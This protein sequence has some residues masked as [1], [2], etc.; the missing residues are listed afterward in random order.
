MSA[1]PPGVPPLADVAHDLMAVKMYSLATFVMVYYDIIITFGDEVERVWRR[2]FTWF[3]VLWFLNQYVPPLG[4]VVIILAFH[5]SAW[6]ANARICDAV[7][8]FPA[9]LGAVTGT[10]IDVIFI[11]RLYATFSAHKAVLVFM[12]PL[13]T[14]KEALAI[15]SVTSGQRL[16]LPPGLVGCILIAGPQGNLR[17]TGVWIAQLCFDA[18]VFALTVYRALALSRVARGGVRSLIDIIVRDGVVY[19]AVIFVADLVN[20]LTFL[21]APVRPFLSRIDMP[22]AD[23]CTRAQPALQAANASFTIAIAPLMVSRLIL[24][25]RGAD[26]AQKTRVRASG[27]S[28]ARTYG[29]GSNAS[30]PRGVLGYVHPMYETPA[31]S[32]NA[33]WKSHGSKRRWKLSAPYTHPLWGPA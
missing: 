6:S 26:A 4:F 29:T 27:G 14:A 21:L 18:T 25:M 22:H 13:L 11:V 33:R 28:G 30:A 17:F 8:F 32:T 3:S 5:N 12:I 15:L 31:T 20:V 10:V 24:N 9:V 1:P 2:K 19:F 7:V 23:V 16:H